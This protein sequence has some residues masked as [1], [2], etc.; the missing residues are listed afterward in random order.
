MIP[1]AVV[2]D[3]FGTLVQRPPGRHPFLQLFKLAKEAGRRP[4]ATDAD[5]VLTHALGLKETAEWLG[6]QPTIEEWSSIDAALEADQQAISLF[7][8]T[9]PALAKAAALGL[10]IAV[11]SNLSMAYG[12]VVQSLLVDHVHAFVFSFDVGAVKP[13]QKI[14]AAVCDALN[15]PPHEVLFV[16]D[17]YEHDVMG[18]RDFGMQAVHLLR[19]PGCSSPDREF[20]TTLSNLP[21]MTSGLRK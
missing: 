12:E 9:C 18:P 6:V 5:H 3:A 15:T 14:Y 20:V 4:K 17:T 1:A 7:P 16:G 19:E 10:K 21:F 2:F 11:C 13:N 8:D